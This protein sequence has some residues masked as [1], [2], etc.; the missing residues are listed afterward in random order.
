MMKSTY[1]YTHLRAKLYMFED[2]TFKSAKYCI[3]E[4]QCKNPVWAINY[5]KMIERQ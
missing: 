4:E 2:L 3:S 5:T 1:G